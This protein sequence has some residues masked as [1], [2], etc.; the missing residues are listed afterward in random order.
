M[1]LPTEVGPELSALALRLHNGAITDA[2]YD[3][4]R[5]IEIALEFNKSGTQAILWIE[6]AG[7]VSK[8]FFTKEHFGWHNLANHAEVNDLPG[9][10]RLGTMSVIR[11]KWVNNLARSF[12]LSTQIPSRL[13]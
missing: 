2:L 7:N 6:C 3:D 11:N 4:S 13:K 8:H 5:F 9:H 1:Q 10:T 12:E